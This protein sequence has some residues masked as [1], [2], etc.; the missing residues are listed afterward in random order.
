M[1]NYFSNLDEILYKGL[2]P[3]LQDNNP[4]EKFASMIS[5]IK[6]NKSTY[7][8]TYDIIFERPFNNKTKYYSKL[9]SS[10][11]TKVT[12]Q[13]L[14]ILNEDKAPQL[15]KYRLNDTLNKK[16]KTKLKDIGEIIKNQQF[17]LS[18]IDPKTTI[19]NRDQ[20]HKTN[21][22]IF[23]LLKT[24]LIH[25]Y[26]EI[27]E[28]FIDFI[29]DELI[30]DD[31]YIQLLFEPVPIKTYLSETPLTI[32]I[33][34]EK[35]KRIEVEAQNNLPDVFNPILDDV[36]PDKKGVAF[37]K[38]MIRNKQRFASFEEK[39]FQNDYISEK[40]AFTGKHGY[41]NQL[42]IIFHLLI[43]KRYFNNYNDSDKKRNTNRNIV[44]FLN[45]RYDVDVDKQFRNLEPLKEERA[46]FIESHYWLQN[47]PSC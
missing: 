16:L 33:D 34:S 17:E 25:I 30:I 28:A 32:P 37:Y 27:Q 39:L 44:K 4:D 26:L 40:Y 11:K 43:E 1:K 18:Y 14:D 45:H 10:E 46:D 2:R 24:S 13:L 6:P 19:F 5:G 31:F 22:F 7:Q 47:L 42:A 12:N 23:Q 41:K 20:D 21:T 15:I 8:L 3:W 35:P 38:D 9:I 29:S 36:R